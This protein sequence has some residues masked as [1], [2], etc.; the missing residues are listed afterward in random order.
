MQFSKTITSVHR[1][2]VF[3]VIIDNN[4]ANILPLYYL[5]LLYLYSTYLLF[6]Y[7]DG[8]KYLDFLNPISVLDK[9]V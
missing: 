3:H 7:L 5:D 9:V 1:W 2:S 8:V 4:Y 6:I